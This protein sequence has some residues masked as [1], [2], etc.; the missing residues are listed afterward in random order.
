MTKPGRLARV[1]F[2][3]DRRMWDRQD[4]QS[5]KHH[6]Y[7]IMWLR[8]GRGRTLRKLA[9]TLDI[10][11]AWAEQISSAHRWSEVAAEWDAEDDRQWAKS[12]DDERRRAM[13]E[14]LDVSR[15]AIELVAEAVDRIRA[16]GE[17][18]PP[19]AAA[20]LL[21]V[22]DRIQRG[23]FGEA[24]ARTEIGGRDGG[25]IEIAEVAAL[26]DEQRRERVRE[27]TGRLRRRTATLAAFNDEGTAA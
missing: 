27:L 19:A 1:E 7:M 8:L 3:A 23:I 10:S 21:G 14:R 2:A 16:T 4:G 6:G 13:R 9:E 25:P 26:D 22:A 15:A 11:V 18:V 17:P 5:V 24:D 12:L 20:Q